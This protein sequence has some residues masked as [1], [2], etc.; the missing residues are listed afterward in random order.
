LNVVLT[1]KQAPHLPEYVN[2]IQDHWGGPVQD[3][4]GRRWPT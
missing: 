2:V 1:C 3:H 4:R